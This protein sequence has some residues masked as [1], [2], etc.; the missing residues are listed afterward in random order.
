MYKL[1]LQRINKIFDFLARHYLRCISFFYGFIVG[2]INVFG[3]LGSANE[4]A[5]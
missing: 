5:D 4:D 3:I 2:N 1:Q